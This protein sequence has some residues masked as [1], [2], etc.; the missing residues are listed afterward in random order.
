MNYD[1]KGND[2]TASVLERLNRCVDNLEQ[3]GKRMRVLQMRMAA[4]VDCGSLALQILG[5]QA[6][7][8]RLNEELQALIL[9]FQQQCLGTGTP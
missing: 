2:M 7:L 8:Q 6:E 5:L 1:N 3:A 4:T 9:A